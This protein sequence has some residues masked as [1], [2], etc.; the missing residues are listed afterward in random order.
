MHGSHQTLI[1][2]NAGNLILRNMVLDSLIVRFAI[3]G[4]S[5]RGPVIKDFEYLIA[6]I[7]EQNAL[8]SKATLTHTGASSVESAALFHPNIVWHLNLVQLSVDICQSVDVNATLATTIATL[9]KSDKFALE[10]HLF[11]RA[12]LLS[13]T[14]LGISLDNWKILFD[15]LISMAKTSADISS[16]AIYMVLYYLAKEIDAHKQLELLRGLTS[17]AALKENI[18]MILNAYR[19]LTSSACVSLRVLAIDLHTT[20]WMAESRTYRFLHDILTAGDGT[21][22]KRDQWEMNVAKAKAIKEICTLK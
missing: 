17:F 14:Q 2:K 10:M 18:A 5:L 21:L 7:L 12:I 3:N 11:I 6:R 15:R 16:D 9:E 22:S 20:L 19:S 4:K 8:A 1:K 13:S